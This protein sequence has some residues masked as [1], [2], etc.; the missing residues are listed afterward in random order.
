[1]TL[2]KTNK[3]ERPT[4]PPHP[5]SSYSNIPEANAGPSPVYAFLQEMR[6]A[7]QSNTGMKDTDPLTLDEILRMP[8]DLLSELWTAVSE[9]GNVD[10]KR[11]VLTHG[12]RDNSLKTEGVNSFLENFL[13]THLNREKNQIMND[14]QKKEQREMVHACYMPLADDGSAREALEY[15]K[16]H[17]FPQTDS[18]SFGIIGDELYYALFVELDVDEFGVAFANLF[19]YYDLFSNYV[20]KVKAYDEELMSDI[21][22]FDSR[23][24][25]SLDSFFNKINKQ[26]GGELIGFTGLGRNDRE[27]LW[28]AEAGDV[29]QKSTEEAML[30]HNNAREFMTTRTEYQAS[31]I[32]T[33]ERGHLQKVVA[34]MRPVGEKKVTAE[35]FLRAMYQQRQLALQAIREGTQHLIVRLEDCLRAV[36]SELEKQ[37]DTLA[38]LQT[39]SQDDYEK[40]DEFMRECVEKLTPIRHDEVLRYITQYCLFIAPAIVWH[41]PTRRVERIQLMYE[42]QN[43]DS[44]MTSKS[45]FDLCKRALFYTAFVLLLYDYESAGAASS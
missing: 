38:F 12:L 17:T 30:A 10:A 42:V 22:K 41:T 8:A 28:M 40:Y 5:R 39:F 29:R 16:K 18:R 20:N 36:R 31:S 7:R 34:S 19:T 33:E 25:A 2:R 13:Q 27:R 44:V 1:M 37:G 24:I 45:P 3:P 11:V 32:T 9:M 6:Q 14:Q 43:L 26:L 23:R 15:F 21:D 35:T 4:R